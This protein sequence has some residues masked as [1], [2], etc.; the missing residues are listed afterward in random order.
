MALFSSKLARLRKTRKTP[1]RVRQLSIP[2]TNFQRCLTI[3][4]FGHDT[5]QHHGGNVACCA[6]DARARLDETCAKEC[7]GSVDTAPM[8]EGW[9]H[10]V[11]REAQ[12]HQ[13][14]K[15]T[16]V[17]FMAQVRGQIAVFQS[18]EPA[19]LYDTSLSQP[20]MKAVVLNSV[21]KS[22]FGTR[23]EIPDCSIPS[24]MNSHF[25]A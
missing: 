16:V 1:L 22:H 12:S 3:S 10:S 14:L 4:T 9:V 6:D 11:V 24:R 25:H 18:R 5:S 17:E 13:G 2:K 19:G 15:T 8:Q 20:Q 21:P 23:T 7:V